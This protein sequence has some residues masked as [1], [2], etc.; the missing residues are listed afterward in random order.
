V[1]PIAT[2]NASIASPRAMPKRMMKSK[3][4]LAGSEDSGTNG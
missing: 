3:C 1:T 4:L 2:E